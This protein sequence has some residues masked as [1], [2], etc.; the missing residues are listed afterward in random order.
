[1][2]FQTEN[3]LEIESNGQQSKFNCKECKVGT[4]PWRYKHEQICVKKTEASIYLVDNTLNITDITIGSCEVY[5]MDFNAAD[6]GNHQATTPKAII[7]L[8]CGEGKI[9][10]SDNLSCV[11]S[12]PTVEIMM[13]DLIYNP[14]RKWNVDREIQEAQ[15]NTTS[16]ADSVPYHSASDSS[17]VH[18]YK[19][20]GCYKNFDNSS[21]I[22]NANLKNCSVAAPIT[23]KGSTNQVYGCVKCK[24]DQQYLKI[25]GT[26]Q[27][28]T[29]VSYNWQDLNAG[30]V[31]GIGYLNFTCLIKTGATAVSAQLQTDSYKYKTTQDKTEPLN[32]EIYQ[33]TINGGGTDVFTCKKCKFGYTGLVTIDEDQICNQKIIKC[34]V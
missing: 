17:K 28:R 8:K 20:T 19:Y 13:Y 33:H 27:E 34:N 25:F 26:N 2:K 12:C 4:Y 32:C 24:T 3:C 15:A 6:A 22:I 21:V 16:A 10:S 23:G 5:A 18:Y 9:P 30:K 7:C 29:T 11:T 14:N 1:M 31:F